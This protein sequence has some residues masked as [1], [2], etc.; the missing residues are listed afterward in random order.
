[1]IRRS[2]RQRRRAR[3]LEK[4]VGRSSIPV[5]RVRGS[6]SVSC[7]CSRSCQS[8]SKM[9][10]RASVIRLGFIIRAS[11]CTP[12]PFHRLAKPDK[13]RIPRASTRHAAAFNDPRSPYRSSGTKSWR[14]S[15]CLTFLSFLFASSI[16]RLTFVGDLNFDF[17]L[18]SFRFLFDFFSRSFVGFWWILL[19]LAVVRRFSLGYL[20]FHH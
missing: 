9:R 6:G 12:V 2:R 5:D 7:S 15:G 3:E 4:F 19:L 13:T 16:G 10:E 1:M 20:M 18:I 17:H 11:A 8:L 14:P